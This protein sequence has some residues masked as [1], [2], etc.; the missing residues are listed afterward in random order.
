V[1]WDDVTDT[2]EARGEVNCQVV[3]AGDLECDAGVF[4]GVQLRLE[5]F[6]GA[7]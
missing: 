1:A 7:Q 6:F 3:N 5:P 4:R 2:P